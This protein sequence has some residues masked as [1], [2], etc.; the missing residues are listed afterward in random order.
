MVTQVEPAQGRAVATAPAGEAVFPREGAGSAD[1]EVASVHAQA[2]SADAVAESLAAVV[3]LFVL[4]AESFDVVALLDAAAPQLPVG[5]HQR[6]MAP[7]NK[8]HQAT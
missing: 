3:E 5:S 7:C 2:A 8:K 1:V 6:S 4:E